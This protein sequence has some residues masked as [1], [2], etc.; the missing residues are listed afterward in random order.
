MLITLRIFKNAEEGYRYL[1]DNPDK[2]VYIKFRDDD[3]KYIDFIVLKDNWYYGDWVYFDGNA[4]M[5][6]FDPNLFEESNKEE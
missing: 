4:Y 3:E 6:N 5:F 1:K 2:N